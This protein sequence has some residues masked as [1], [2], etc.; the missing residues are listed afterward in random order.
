MKNLY[1]AA[2]VGLLA[3]MC[4][5]GCDAVDT[6]MNKGGDTTCGKFITMNEKDQREAV[7]KMLKERSGADP[8][9]LEVTGTRVAVGAYC[10]TVGTDSSKISDIQ[11]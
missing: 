10:R 4:T 11:R 7:S 5:A 3:V 6:V 1:K 9:N 2:A 8:S